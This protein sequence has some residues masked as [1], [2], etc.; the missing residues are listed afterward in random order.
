VLG[1]AGQA[2]SYLCE[3]LLER[4]YEVRGIVR[5]PLDAVMPN[6]EAIRDQLG[7]VQADVGDFDSLAEEIR[8]FEPDEIYNLASVSFGPDAWRDPIE[9]ARVAVVG[10]CNLLEAIRSSRPQARLFQASSAW[11]FGRPES[12]PQNERTPY[13]P[14]E[15]YGAAK[16]YADFMARAY[17]EAHGVFVCSGILYNHE[18]PRRPE[19][20]VT[21]KITKTA[22]AIKLGLER[23]LLL[24]E[25]DA[26][27]DWGYAKDFVQAAWLMLQADE[28]DDYVV[29]TGE[30]HTVREFCEIAFGSLELDWNEHVRVDPALVRG[31]AQVANLIGD[32]A[33]ARERLH[34]TPSVTFEELVVVMV[35]ADVRELSGDPAAYARLA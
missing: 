29:A 15:P 30:A 10:V 14:V 25:L 21:R 9:T 24:G 13:A 27:R 4:D 20:F 22:A 28:P 1:A 34:W 26:V 8:S 3:L 7:L 2:G 33:A 32:A 6:I 16:A 12:A 31:E 5:R 35:E 11:V 23:E 19:R 18:S 17:R